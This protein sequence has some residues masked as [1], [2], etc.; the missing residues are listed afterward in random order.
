MSGC[1]NCVWDLYREEMEE[2]AARQRKAHAG[3]VAGEADKAR[4]MRGR[5]KR[6][7]G[8]VQGEGG[9]GDSDDGGIG[10]YEGMDVVQEGLFEGVPVGIREFMNTEKRLRERREAHRR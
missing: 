8:D 4:K 3:F 2:W 10:G 9:V 1:V 7:E 5:G 6:K